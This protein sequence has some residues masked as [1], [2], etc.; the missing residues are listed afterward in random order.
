M[1]TKTTFMLAAMTALTLGVGSAMAQSE[2]PSSAAGDY[3]SQQRHAAPKTVKNWWGRV[4]AGAS[5][6][7]HAHVGHVLPF[8]GDYTTLANPG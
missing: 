7:E 3:F 6:V 8:D 4:Q 1:K 2:V 5:D